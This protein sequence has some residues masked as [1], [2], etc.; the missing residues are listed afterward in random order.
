MRRKPQARPQLARCPYCIAD[1]TAY[2]GRWQQRF[3]NH[4][5][6][7]L[8]LGCGKGNFIAELAVKHPELNFIAIDIKSEVLW[9]TM[10]HID[11]AFAEQ[12]KAPD[13][14]LILSHDIE[15]IGLMLDESDVIERIYINFCNPWPKDSYKKHRLTHTRQLLQYRAFLRDGGEIWFKTDDD[16]LFAESLA[17]FKESGFVQ[18]YLTYDLHA[19]GF[20]G[21]IETEHERLFSAQGIPIKFTIMRKDALHGESTDDAVCEAGV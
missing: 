20:A 5:P 2:K 8:E 18:T 16:Q 1:P 6:I 3:G 17:Y 12:G 19:S 15:R 11:A 14:V 9:D 7:Y 21:N 4:A 13:N 10:K